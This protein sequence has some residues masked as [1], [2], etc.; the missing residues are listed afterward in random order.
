MQKW[1]DAAEKYDLK[2]EREQ[3]ERRKEQQRLEAI[4]SATD[5]L[6]VFLTTSIGEA[7]IKLLKASG[8]E[9]RIAE[10]PT[11][12]DSVKSIR[13]TGAGFIAS[14]EPL[15]A[16]PQ[17][18]A[19]EQEWVSANIVVEAWVKDGMKEPATLIPWLTVQ[20]DEIANAAPSVV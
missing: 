15:H 4:T 20:L 17:R 2:R 13:F 10:E 9:I 18:E 5:D 1:L 12:L 19:S 6:T 8:Q 16:E 7:A 11:G 14:V 3:E